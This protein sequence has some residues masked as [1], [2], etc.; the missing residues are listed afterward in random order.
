MGVETV[1]IYYLEFEVSANNTIE[2]PNS[3]LILFEKNISRGEI[4]EVFWIFR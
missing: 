3:S 2:T 1:L 4:S